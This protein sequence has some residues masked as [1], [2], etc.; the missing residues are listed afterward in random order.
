MAS[1]P[2]VR[3]QYFAGADD[4]DADPPQRRQAGHGLSDHGPAERRV[5][6]RR[7][8]ETGECRAGGSEKVTRTMIESERRGLALE[9]DDLGEV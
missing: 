9:F 7:E 1:W 8:D 5:D 3:R 4:F 6:F 2:V